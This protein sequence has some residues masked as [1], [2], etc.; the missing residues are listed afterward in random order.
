MSI[1]HSLKN[2]GTRPLHTSV[3]DHNFLVL[4]KQ[5][6][7]PAFSITFPFAVTADPP[8]NKDQAEVEKNK[9][10]YRKKLEGKDTVYFAIEGFGKSAGDYKIHL[11]NADVKAGMMISG[12]RPL[13]KM[14]LWSIRSII[15]VEPFVDISLEPGNQSTWKYDYEYYTLP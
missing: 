6:T 15:A 3:Y 11:E 10:L 9:V 8:P 2:T 13:A 5:T 7:G 12:D 14:S 1:A 4:D